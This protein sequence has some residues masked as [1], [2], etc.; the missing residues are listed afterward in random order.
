MN[1]K[2][3]IPDH[4]MIGTSSSA[5]QIEGCAGK[6]ETQ[7]SWADLF[8]ETDPSR[9]H[10]QIGPEKASDF[11]HHYKE[12]I[13]TMADFKMN[14]FRFTIQ[15]ARFMKDALKKE[16]DKEAVAY[17]RDVIQTIKVHGMKPIVSLEHWDIPAI[18]LEKYDGWASR[19]TVD[20]YVDYVQKVLDEFH[21]EVDLWFAFTEPN[22]P[23]DNGYIKK[24]WYPFVHDPQRAYQAHF[25]KILATTK[26]VKAMEPYKEDG[27]RLGVMLH[28]TPIYARSGEARDVQAAYYAD[29]FQVRIY[30]DPYLKGEFP[31]E[32]LRKLEE[33]NCMFAYEQADFEDIKK[34]RI[35]MLGIDYYFPIRVKARETAYDKDVFHPEFYYEP[36]VMPG[37][38]YNADR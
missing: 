10:D 35:D 9:W 2:I 1:Q 3:L 30:L 17:Y 15:W 24:I 16:V 31:Q 29:L 25:H 6:S 32:L 22:I 33:H 26:A 21:D 14:T 4:F 7:K 12:D 8:Y 34:Y 37:R 23:I 27:C 13:K 5:W 20:L 11:Y 28:M 19:E 36:W 18:L 38:K